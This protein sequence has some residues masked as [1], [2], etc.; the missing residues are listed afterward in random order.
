MARNSDITDPVGPLLS[1][2]AYNTLKRRSASRKEATWL[3]TASTSAASGG[4]ALQVNGP[5]ATAHQGALR[6]DDDTR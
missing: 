2:Q 3:I 4:A 6:L 1:P 5:E